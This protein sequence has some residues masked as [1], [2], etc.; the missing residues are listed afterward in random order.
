MSAAPEVVFRPTSPPRKWT[1]EAGPIRE[2]CEGWLQGRV[3]NACAGKTHL[4]HSGEIVR[5]DINTDRE[6]DLH[7]D[8]AELAEH[9]EPDSFDTVVFDPPWSLYQSNLRYEGEMVG[10]ATQAK[11]AF[12]TLLRPHGR[13]IE[14]GYSG[15]CMPARLGY[16]R[17]ERVWWNHTG[18]MR[19]TLGCVDEN[20]PEQGER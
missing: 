17:L 6:A 9:F 11:E 18:R 13:V 7:V 8:V 16:D 15:S 12:H 10:H 2:W 20:N 4:S 14:L 1:F 5:N 3:L 19:D